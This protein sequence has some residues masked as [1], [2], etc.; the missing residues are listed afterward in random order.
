MEEEDKWYS[1]EQVPTMSHLVKIMDK[2]KVYQHK[3]I[4]HP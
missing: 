1:L 2:K 3:K 4:C